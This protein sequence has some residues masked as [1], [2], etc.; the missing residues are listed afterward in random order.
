MI[1]SIFLI[2]ALIP[3]FVG[4]GYLF[5]PKTMKKVQG[6]FRKK[7]DKLD[8]YAYKRHR[9]VGFMFTAVGL[10]M[11]YTYFQPVWIYN[12]FVVARVVMSVLFP[13]VFQ[14]QQVDATPM[15]CI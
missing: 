1:N 9:F 7:I 8:R 4:I 6:W 15:V 11:I 13:D 14:I 3:F 12:V 5:K 2:T 10:M